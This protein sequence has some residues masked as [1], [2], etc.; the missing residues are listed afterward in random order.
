MVTAQACCADE[1]SEAKSAFVGRLRLV[2]DS[3]KLNDPESIA[4]I[5]DLKFE[6]VTRQ[7]TPTTGGD[8][9]D[10]LATHSSVEKTAVLIGA[11]WYHS[12]PS[13]VQNIE[14]KFF[15]H[16]RK[17][18]PP[19]LSY[20]VDQISCLDRHVYR[21]RDSTV[22]RM[23]F[24]DLPGFA[25]ITADD[26]KTYMPDAKFIM[27]TDMHYEYAYRGKQGGTAGTSLSFSYY[28]NIPCALDAKVAQNQ[29]R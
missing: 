18:G 14:V 1:A 16:A 20:T 8:C 24:I 23:D 13:G 19:S 15:E 22:A 26:I 10:N 7:K 21:R 9:L 2:A 6:I 12:L 11:N 3:G 29:A 4:R 27:G 5:L 17:M 28:S 25:C